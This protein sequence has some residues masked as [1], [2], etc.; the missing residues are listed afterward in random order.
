[1]LRPH[2]AGRSAAVSLLLPRL[3]CRSNQVGARFVGGSATRLPVAPRS[4]DV[5]VASDGLYSW[6]LDEGDRAAALREIHDA[7]APGGSA[8]LTEH[9]RPARFAEFVAEVRASPLRVASVTYRHDRPCYQFEGWLKA[10]RHWRAAR[11]LRRSERLAR[12]LSALGR[13]F[14][15][16]GSRHVCVVATRDG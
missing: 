7:L 14:G 11:A 16:A 12:V 1:M 8:V 6:Q 5:I 13:P 10:V 15:A 9:M 3:A 2:I 4:F